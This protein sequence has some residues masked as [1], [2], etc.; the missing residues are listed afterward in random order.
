MDQSGWYF[1]FKSRIFLSQDFFQLRIFLPKRRIFSWS[2][3]FCN[4]D[5]NFYL[6][7]RVFLPSGESNSV[8]LSRIFSR[9][10]D[11]LPSASFFCNSRIPNMPCH[12]LP[13]WSN[14]MVASRF[15]GYIAFLYIVVI[16]QVADGNVEDLETFLLSVQDCICR[17]AQCTAL[18][19]VEYIHDC[20][21]GFV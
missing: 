10:Q 13:K 3:K 1:F 16:L 9:S 11:F 7:L 2:W 20:S 14:K 12:L 17:I 4:Q 18:G 6:Q 21:E 15:V 19:N 5:G 8:N